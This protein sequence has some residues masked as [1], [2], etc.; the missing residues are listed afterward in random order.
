[1]DIEGLRQM[2]SRLSEKNM[3]RCFHTPYPSVPEW[4]ISHLS[5][6]NRENAEFLVAVSEGEI[7]GHAM[8][9]GEDEEAKFAVAVED[10]WQSRGVDKSLL[11]RLALDAK[12]RDFETFTATVLG[13][14][15]RMV[16]LLE[17]AFSKVEY[18][19]KGGAFHMRIPLS[20]AR[21]APKPEESQRMKRLAS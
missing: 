5:N 19:M 20:V 21:S 16:G 4:T 6:T 17:A 9:V 2:F 3:Y 15:R 11:F 18:Q 8:F 13:E 10:E 12:R 7:V 14:N 1:M